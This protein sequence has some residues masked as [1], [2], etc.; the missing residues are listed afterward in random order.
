MVCRLPDL[1]F[2]LAGVSDPFNLETECLVGLFCR[3]PGKGFVSQHTIL[4]I[5]IDRLRQFPPSKT[6]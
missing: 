1:I 6:C 2:F 5:I 4:N 3:G